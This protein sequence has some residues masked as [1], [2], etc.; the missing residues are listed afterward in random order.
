MQETQDEPLIEL[1][2]EAEKQ[3]KSITN[4]W[5]AALFR[6]MAWSTAHDEKTHVCTHWQR[7]KKGFE[8]TS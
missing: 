3:K 1:D 2:E 7:T 6:N 4:C 5:A 8:V